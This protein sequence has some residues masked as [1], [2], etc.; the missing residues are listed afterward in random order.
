MDYIE[1]AK[2]IRET[3]FSDGCPCGA[4]PLCEGEDCI[5]VQAADAIEKLNAEV[6][7][8]KHDVERYIQINTDLNDEYEE[9]LQVRDHQC[10]VL[11]QF[12]GETGIR[13]AFE[14]MDDYWQLLD[15]YREL[16]KAAKK[17]HTWIFL[18][19]FDEQ[20]AYNECGLSD[21]MNATLGY[22]GRL[23]IAVPKEE[24]E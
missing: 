12:G 19:S 22:G 6:E 20:A 10:D 2:S 15:K 18:N 17:M 9:L 23:E 8:L 14:R 5:I 4:E 1:L 7:A 11:M 21:E 24:T 3:D 13:Q 16:L